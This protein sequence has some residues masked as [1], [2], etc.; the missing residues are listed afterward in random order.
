MDLD[1]KISF[2]SG[3]IFT[4]ATSINMLG[5]IQAAAV[6][7]IGGFFGLLGKHFFYYVRDE[8]R[9][10]IKNKKKWNQ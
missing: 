1:N 6:G 9:D 3:F 5:W 7:L 8:Y 2:L 10:W 4:A